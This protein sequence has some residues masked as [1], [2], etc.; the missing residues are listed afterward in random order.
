MKRI[1]IMIASLLLIVGVAQGQDNATSMDA[2][3]E[4]IQQGQTRDSA[5]A[6]QREQRFAQDR[7]EQ[8]NLLNQSRQERSRQERNSE[9]LEQLFEDNQTKIVAARVALDERLGALKELFGVLQTVT[10]DAQGRF[11]ESLTSIQFPDREDFL[12]Q[13]GSKMVET[14]SCRLR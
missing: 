6:R 4:M 13:L 8:Q 7:N 2:L 12:V 11:N 10:G 14:I 1:T 3:L 5:E 9:R